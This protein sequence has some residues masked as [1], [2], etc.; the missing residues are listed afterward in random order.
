MKAKACDDLTSI[1]ARLDAINR[2]H[3]DRLAKLEETNRVQ[4]AINREQRERIAE[5]EG[6]IASR[7]GV[8]PA[9]VAVNT[10]TPKQAAY[11]LGVTEQRVYQLIKSG[12]LP[13]VRV[14]GRQRVD[15]QALKTRA[16]CK[17]SLEA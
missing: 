17:R 7:L 13:S 5:L 16:T 10:I 3:R 9:T 15:A 4:E 1:L 8:L 11:E 6:I 12:K 2:Q 14:G